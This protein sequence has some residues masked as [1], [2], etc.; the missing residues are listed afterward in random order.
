MIKNFKT[1]LEERYPQIK[2]IVQKNNGM[3]SANNRGIILSTTD[4]AF[5]INPDVKFYDDTLQE[6]FNF[7]KK[8]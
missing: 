1:K 7:S 3:G 4:Y 5:V 2:V 6:I 8:K